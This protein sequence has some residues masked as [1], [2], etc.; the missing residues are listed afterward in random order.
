MNPDLPQQFQ[1]ETEPVSAGE[2]LLLEGQRLREAGETLE[3]IGSITRAIVEFS[4]EHNRARLAHALLDRAICYQH[5]CQS[6][7]NDPAF[8][9]LCKKDAE[10]MLEIAEAEKIEDELDQA[11]FINAKAALLFG[12]HT[13]AVELFRLA[14]EKISRVRAA[15][16]GDWR[17]NLGKAMYLSGEK[18]QGIQEILDGVEQVQEFSDEVDAYTFNVWVSGGYLRLAELLRLDDPEQSARYLAEA[19]RIIDSD[20]SQVVR[21]IQVEN[22]EKT[23]ITGL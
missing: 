12:D 2:Q 20:E 19:K 6:H 10:A 1:P 18:E 23:G 3:A 22:F 14:I 16:M 15:Q 11:Y 5:L 4:D 21:R 9:V 7:G 13:K 17:T 8:A